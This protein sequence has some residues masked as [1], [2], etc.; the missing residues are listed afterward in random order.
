MISKRCKSAVSRHIPLG[1]YRGFTLIELMVAVAVLGVVSGIAMQTYRNYVNTSETAMVARNYDQ[2]LKYVRTSFL[3]SKQQVAIGMNPG[4]NLPASTN[5]WIVAINP[6][7]AAAPGGGP[8]YESGQGNTSTG[9]IGI[10][11][12]GNFASIDAL[13]TITRPAYNGVPASSMIVDQRG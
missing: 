13:V 12:T 7:S 11:F 8:A 4:S 1:M 10:D 2:A 6:S 3:R 9:A 5:D